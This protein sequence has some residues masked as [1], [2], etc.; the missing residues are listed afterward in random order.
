MIFLG[1]NLKHVSHDI[2][3]LELSIC[4]I[5]NSSEYLF[6]GVIISHYIKT[7]LQRKPIMK[8]I[9]IVGVYTL[10]I[11]SISRTNFVGKFFACYVG[12]AMRKIFKIMF[13]SNLDVLVNSQ[14]FSIN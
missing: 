7:I 11:M 10:A 9:Q 3:F 12:Q 8:E 6:F 2:Y 14:Y 4:F 5:N 1:Q 13:L